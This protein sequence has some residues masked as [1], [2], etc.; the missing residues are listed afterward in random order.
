RLVRVSSQTYEM[1]RA[2]MTPQS[3]Q[4]LMDRAAAL[5][6]L[7]LSEAA[8]LAGVR[9][10]ADL[11]RAKG[12]TGSLLEVLLGATA[13][14]RDEPDFE[15]LGIE[16][17]T[18]PL[19][20]DGHPVETTFVCTI[21]LLSVAHT[22]WEQSRVF[23]KLR[24]VLWV[25]VHGE[26][27]RAIAERRIGTPF[28]WSPDAEQEAGLRWDWEELAGKIGTG[29]VDSITGHAGTYLQVRPKAADSRARRRGLDAEGRS[30]SV[31][32]RGFYLRQKF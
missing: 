21:D 26:R 28:L 10:P 20:L 29:D 23:R 18:I 24:R 5:A 31:L 4:E 19:R 3:E 17:K 6:G 15:A 14:S 13:G 30:I 27:A 2:A 9:V 22:E 12:W 11:K 7:S 32:P 25:P 8:G 1:S 16:L